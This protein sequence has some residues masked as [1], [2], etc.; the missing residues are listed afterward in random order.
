LIFLTN[1]SFNRHGSLCVLRSQNGQS[2]WVVIPVVGTS[3]SVVVELANHT[4]HRPNLMA[5]PPSA[6]WPLPEH[7]PSSKIHTHRFA[8][9]KKHRKSSLL[10]YVVSCRSRI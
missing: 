9:K 5:L 7:P 1:L 8:A 2:D 6:Y 10:V 3:N 4:E